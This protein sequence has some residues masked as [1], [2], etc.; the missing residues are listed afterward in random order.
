MSAPSDA[1]P[2]SLTLHEAQRLPTRALARRLLGE[3][4]AL[5]QEAEIPPG[6]PGHFGSRIVLSYVTFATAPRS[7]GFPGLCMA[8]RLTVNFEPVPGSG[9]GD[10]PP[11]RIV[12]L[13]AGRVYRIVG[14]TTDRRE[15][16]DGSERAQ[17]AQ[18]ARSGPVLSHRPAR[19]FFSEQPFST[20]PLRMPE[21]FLASRALQTAIAEARR[22]PVSR[23]TCTANDPAL[24]P[25]Q[26][27]ADPRSAL[28]ALSPDRLL[29]VGLNR[30]AEN[31][32]HLCTDLYLE[33]GVPPRGNE[34][35]ALRVMIEI[36]ADDADPP[37]DS[38][39]ILAVA[40]HYETGID[41]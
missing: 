34:S 40:I 1:A 8:D 21:A 26:A 18:C 15:G 32:A 25:P 2:A 27:C 11:S 28:A 17:D 41:D 37:P 6:S 5:Y 19:H 23:V 16:T 35:T 22:G 33:S 3:S 14:D 36:D 7:A 13:E 29:S 30:C 39:H 20:L 12:H 24:A 9:R 38:L 4:G 10:D 31:P